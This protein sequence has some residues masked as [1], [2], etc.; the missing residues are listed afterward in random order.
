MRFGKTGLSIG[1]PTY[2]QGFKVGP[3]SL[4]LERGNYRL[5]VRPEV[6]SLFVAMTGLPTSDT[7]LKYG[8]L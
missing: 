5:Q 4:L 8:Q 7:N 2:L 1:G 3:S 6:T